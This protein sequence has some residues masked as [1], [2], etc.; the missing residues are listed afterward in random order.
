[1]RG[2][3]RLVIRGSPPSPS[4]RRRY[5]GQVAAALLRWTPFAWLATRSSRSRGKCERRVVEAPGVAPRG[6]GCRRR[7]R[8]RAVLVNLLSAG[9]FDVFLPS[10]GLPRTAPE[11]TEFLET[12]WRR[13]ERSASGSVPSPPKRLAPGSMVASTPHYC[14]AHVA[15]ACTPVFGSTSSRPAASGRSGPAPARD[16]ECPVKYEYAASRVLDIVSVSRGWAY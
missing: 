8:E 9:A 12:L 2:E 13:R 15:A 5:G 6:W 16:G 3:R 4:R 10:T 7:V 1:L 11:S 14:G